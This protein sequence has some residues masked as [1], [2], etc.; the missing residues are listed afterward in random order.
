MLDWMLLN[1]LWKGGV[2]VV[3]EKPFAMSLAEAKKIVELKNKY[4]VKLTVVHSWLFSHIMKKT[5]LSLERKEVGDVLGV[6]MDLLHT[7]NDSMV[8]DPS[9]W[10]HSLKAGRFGEMLPHPLY[11]MRAIL[12]DVR[13]RYVSGSKL[14]SYPWMPI[15]ELR[16]L[17][18]DTE[19]RMASIYVSFNSIRP[20]TTLK[21]FGTDGI[22][23]VNLSNNILV[24]KQYREVRNIEVFMDNLRFI[25]N[26]I[27]SSFSIGGA[28]IIKQYQG[29]HTEFIKEFVN[30]LKKN[31]KPPVTAEEALEV[32]KLHSELSS[33]IHDLYFTD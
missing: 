29:M 16:I 4:G 2:H 10:C 14:G 15:D 11:V 7:K 32:V 1:P 19:G 25:K 26:I 8:A 5:L 13:V 3:I 27:I 6:E 12:G 24:K 9:H 31:I 20:E 17:L 21:I 22:L 33:K 28:L 23:E 30:S 18:Y